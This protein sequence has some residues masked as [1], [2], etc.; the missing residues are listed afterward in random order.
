[1]KSITKLSFLIAVLISFTTVS[2]Q[3]QS[4]P[5]EGSLGLR[6]NFTGQ[7]A[8]EVPYMLNDKLSLAPFLGL[9]STQDQSTNFSLGVRPRYYFSQD[10]SL[11]TYVTGA[12]GFSNT[13]FSNNNINSVTNFDLMIGY[14]AE[15][16]FSDQLSISSDANL[17]TRF[18]D[19]ATNIATSARISA[20]VYF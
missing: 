12:L 7:T 2:L 15:Y 6:A 14:G 10:R 17:G 1:M 5:E 13:S 3:A 18:G 8:I 4:I 9:N 16:F 20:S 11:A 19:S